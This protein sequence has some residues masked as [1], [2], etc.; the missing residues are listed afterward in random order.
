MS[1]EEAIVFLKE[2]LEWFDKTNWNL[3][4]EGREYSRKFNEAIEA[5]EDDLRIRK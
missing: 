2:H 3:T 1:S 4:S 5:L